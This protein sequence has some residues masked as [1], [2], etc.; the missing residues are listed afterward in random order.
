GEPPA[1]ELGLALG[2]R[3]DRRYRLAE[4]DEAE[5]VKPRLEHPLVQRQD[6]ARCRDELRIEEWEADLVAGRIDDRV[7]PLD[8][9]VAEPDSIAEQLGHIGLGDSVAR[10]EP[11]QQLAGDGRMGLQE[12]VIR[13]RQTE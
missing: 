6:I 12:V 11:Q 13:G 9:S 7:D 8:A 1:G 5:V 10:A 4:S 2:E 3:E